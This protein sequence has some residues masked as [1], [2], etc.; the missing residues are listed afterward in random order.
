MWFGGCNEYVVWMFDL[1]GWLFDDVVLVVFNYCGLGGS[2]GWFL[3][4]VCVVDVE[5]IVFWVCVCF[6]FGLV[7]LYLVG[8]SL[9][10]GI[11]M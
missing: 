8:C 4:V 10:S 5:V 6:G 7:C 3:E 2:G 1:V 9:G 11:V